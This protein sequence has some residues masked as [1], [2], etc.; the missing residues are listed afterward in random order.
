MLEMHKEYNEINK[1]VLYN[2][3]LFKNIIKMTNSCA[4]RHLNPNCPQV[5]VFKHCVCFMQ[6]IFYYFTGVFNPNSYVSV[7]SQND[8]VVH[9]YISSVLFTKIV[10]IT[11]HSFLKYIE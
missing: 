2:E 8:S 5:D 4:I 3:K 9:V 6:N 7:N 11:T 10:I 1:N